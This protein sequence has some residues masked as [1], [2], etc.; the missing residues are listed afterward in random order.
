MSSSAYERP[1]PR[2]RDYIRSVRAIWRA[3]QGDDAL[4]AMARELDAQEY[5]T[6]EFGDFVWLARA[7]PRY[8]VVRRA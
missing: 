2:L 1:G 8:A 6:H 3:F 4:A 5:Q 7:E